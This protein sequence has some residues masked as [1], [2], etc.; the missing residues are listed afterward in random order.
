MTARVEFLV[1]SAK[2]V[3]KVA[4]A[5]LRFK[6]A[7]QETPAAATTPSARGQRPRTGA[8]TGTGPR[9]R[10]G[11]LWTVDGAG[12]LKAVPVRTGITDGVS[13]EVSGDGLEPGLQVVSGLEKAES[14][15]TAANPLQPQGRS[16]GGR[17]GPGGF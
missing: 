13:T 15:T 9:T 12:R 17:R 11:Q 2:D 3:M 5:A 6:P 7:G 1:Q 8:E 10:R 4:N 16:G 14:V